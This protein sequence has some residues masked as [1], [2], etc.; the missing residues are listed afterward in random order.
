V[1]RPRWVKLVRDVWLSRARVAAMVLAIALSVAAVAAFLD[2]RAILGREISRNYLADHPASATLHLSAPVTADDVAV[3]RARPG[4][5]DAVARDTVQARI[6][7]G[8]GA[9]TPLLLFVSAPD[10]PRRISTVQVEQGTWPPG[11]DGLFL[12]RTA[13]P[14]LG[15]RVGERVEVR[16]PGGPTATLTVTGSVHDAGVAPAAQEHAAYGQVGTTAL[17][18]LGLPQQLTELKIA[19][20]SPAR[21]SGDAAAVTATARQVAA[22]LSATHPGRVTRIDV[23]APLRHPHYGQMVT[24]GFVLLACG[25]TALLLS[26]ILVATMLGGMLTAQIR[27]L[28]AMKAVGARTGQLLGMYLSLAVVLSGTATALALAP[29]LAAGR[30]LASTAAGLLNLDLHDRSV[31]WWVLAAVLLAGIGTPLLVAL[32]P[33]VSGTRRTVREAIDDHGAGQAGAVGR[34]GSAFGRLGGLP[35]VSRVDAMALR[36]LGRRPGRLALT[37]GLLAVAGATFI[38]GLNAARGWDA[39]AADGVAHRHDDLEVRL[40]RPVSA[41]RLLAATEAVPGIRTAQA[42]NRIPTAAAHPGQVDVARVYPDESHSSFT[43]LAPPADTPLIRLPLLSGRWLRAD[44]AGTVVL[45]SLAADIQLGGAK[46]GDRVLLTVGARQVPFTVAGVV[47]DFGTQAAAYVTD[48]QYAALDGDPPT[49]TASMVRVVTTAHDPAGRR[50]A[51]QRLTESLDA[52]GFGVQT[53][54]TS[55]DL[56]SALDGHV[57]V[58]IEALVAIALLVG[59]VGL[60]GLGSALSTSV[61]ER[62]REFG[63]MHAIG[64]TA[65][66]VRSLVVTEATATALGGVLLATVVSLPLT[67][68]FGSFL[69]GMAFRQPLPSAIGPAPV[70]L[71]T[72]LALAGA[73]VAAAGAARRASRLTVR[74]AL[75]VL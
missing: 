53:A 28:G 44:D 41:D 2:A 30:L 3:A 60:L 52:Q 49:P 22:A 10:D 65:R 50:A 36:G 54:L 29:G 9:W 27:Q 66:T 35:G 48:R 57:F 18:R 64:A 69:G 26:S 8:N 51:L 70:L 58:L 23:P 11:A 47:S 61:T 42:W 68:V 17:A 71:W 72:T 13:L 21:P 12:E 37:V 63:V 4:V 20:G 56:R 6:R 15:V 74:E 31:P 75:T 62:T 73:A 45:N 33:L 16:A 43:I 38:T 46:V 39:L 59:F 32:P 55:D 24:V 40:D 34:I 67:V 7:V 25:L 1:S 14:F 5:A 19:V